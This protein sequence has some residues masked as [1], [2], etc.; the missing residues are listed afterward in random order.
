V[1]TT[2]EPHQERTDFKQVRY[3]SLTG[4]SIKERAWGS[5]GE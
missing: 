4:R 2:G 5:S 3:D 1:Y